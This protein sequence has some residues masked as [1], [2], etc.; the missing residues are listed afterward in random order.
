MSLSV[1]QKAISAIERRNPGE[2]LGATPL[3][4]ASWTLGVPGI[5]AHLPG[6]H[7]SLDA[8]HD[9]AAAAPGDGAAAAGF[10][11]ALLSRLPNGGDI[12]W[13]HAFPQLR[14]HGRLYPPGLARFGLAPERFVEITA[15]QR[16]LAWVMEEAVRAGR[17]GAI[18]GEGGP[19]GFTASRRLQLACAKTRTPCLLL[20][21]TARRE[22]S[23]AASRWRITPMP[24]H[25]TDP[26]APGQAGWRITLTRCRGGKPGAWKVYW[27]H[28]THSFY[29]AAETLDRAAPR[30]QRS[31]GVPGAFRKAG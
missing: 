5:D 27:N 8:F 25:A 24:S 28:A 31:S 3:R 26:A 4:A 12:L 16:D 9:L 14:E 29:L 23:A 18:V 20:N 1:L 21:L 30:R 2:A 19:I 15:R 6:G 13:C 7:L 10:T 11:L 17:I 22:S